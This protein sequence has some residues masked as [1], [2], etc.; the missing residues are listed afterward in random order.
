M[1]RRV[2]KKDTELNIVIPL[3]NTAK[4]VGLMSS[5]D[6]NENDDIYVI[7]DAVSANISGDTLTVYFNVGDYPFL[8]DDVVINIDWGD[9]FIDNYNESISQNNFIFQYNKTYLLGGEK[10]IVLRVEFDWG[11]FSIVKKVMVN[12]DVSGDNTN[13]YDDIIMLTK[14]NV[15]FLVEVNKPQV[16]NDIAKLNL[17]NGV[18][19]K[20]IV[21]TTDTTDCSDVLCV[22]DHL[23]VNELTGAYD[24]NVVD[25]DTIYSIVIQ[26]LPHYFNQTQNKL[27][28]EL[29]YNLLNNLGIYN[30]YTLQINNVKQQIHFQEPQFFGIDFPV[31][32][33]SQVFI[34]RDKASPL[35]TIYKL[36]EVNNILELERNGNGYFKINNISDLKI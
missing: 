23:I 20:D 6:V 36:S 22:R 3:T 24:S 28:L 12:N 1:H 32:I 18:Y 33:Q 9:G 26:G 10:T 29:D 5:A 21:V 8:K 27:F 19:S 16:I 35:E 14:R 13:C 30:D 7:N 34:E 4:S 25:G 11:S 17:N 2:L 15:Y 31:D